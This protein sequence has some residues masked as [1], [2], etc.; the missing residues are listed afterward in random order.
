VVDRIDVG[1]QSS[2]Q[3][4]L[5]LGISKEDARFVMPNTAPGEIVISANFRELR[6]IIVVRGSRQGQW[7][8]RQLAT[9]LLRIVKPAALD[10]FFDLVIPPNSCVERLKPGEVF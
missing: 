9:H 8:V 5:A 1:S 10:V 6:R 7:H 2:L 3:R 4:L